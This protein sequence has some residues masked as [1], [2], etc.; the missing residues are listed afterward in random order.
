M[1][2]LLHH[3][4]AY[5]MTVREKKTRVEWV[6]DVP[7]KLNFK[8]APDITEMGPVSRAKESIKW[9]NQTKRDYENERELVTVRR[10]TTDVIYDADV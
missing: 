1:T 10:V 3:S 2:N 5:E 7:Q 6:E 8:T 9:W 4:I